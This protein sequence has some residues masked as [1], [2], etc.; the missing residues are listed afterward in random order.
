MEMG[1]STRR[2]FLKVSGGSLLGAGLA[3][4][5]YL[6]ADIASGA[7]LAAT[8][9]ESSFVTSSEALRKL[10][11]GNLRYQ[12]GKAIRP[13]Q[14]PG[15][16][17][18]TAQKQNPFAIIFSCVDSRVPPEI[19]FDQ[20]LGD[21]F[22]IRTAA[23]VIDKAA[24]GSLEFG[25]AELHIPLLM[26]L[27]HERCGAVSA[28]VKAVDNHEDAPGSIQSLVDYIR[29]S[30][31][32]A[33]GTGAARLDDAVRIN[34]RRTVQILLRE[35]TILTDAVNGHKLEIVAARYDLDTG[36]VKLI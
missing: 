11:Q 16:R 5:P 13:D 32:T 3:S 14:T 35:S 1:P 31:L 29:P 15:R 23:H 27:G 8:E 6:S 19:V 7:T 20:G 18:D 30:V 9:L 2:S 36:V 17:R 24:L 10:L 26:V 28:T 33:Q 22:V 25:V 21:L 34:S 4:L 12:K